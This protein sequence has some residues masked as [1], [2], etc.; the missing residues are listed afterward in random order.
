MPRQKYWSQIAES[1]GRWKG[2]LET[3]CDSSDRLH[4][5]PCRKKPATEGGKCPVRKSYGY[6]LGILE[7]IARLD[8]TLAEHLR[9]AASKKNHRISVLVHSKSFFGFNIRVCFRYN[10]CP[11][12]SL[13]VLC[14]GIGLHSR[15][16]KRGK[17][18]TY[19]LHT[20]QKVCSCAP[21][22]NYCGRRGA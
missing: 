13:Q 9:K 11:D 16:F 6:V 2:T 8:V 12:Q 14:S 1:H 20:P 19:F 3:C 18:L 5:L 7:L 4:T 15:Y 21:A 10:L 17:I 22:A